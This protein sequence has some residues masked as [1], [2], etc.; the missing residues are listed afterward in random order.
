MY[1]QIVDDLQ[2]CIRCALPTRHGLCSTCQ[3]RLSVGPFELSPNITALVIQNELTH[4]LLSTYDRTG[5]PSSV[6]PWLRIL[7]CESPS[8]PTVMIA[9]RNDPLCQGVLR[10][11]ADTRPTVAIGTKVRN[12]LKTLALTRSPPT[13]A[14][15]PT[16][17]LVT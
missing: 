6:K 17:S 7:S 11:L 2:P 14:E 1:H 5:H 12:G 3:G 15:M 16:L 4:R 10:R 13:A 9:D 8:V